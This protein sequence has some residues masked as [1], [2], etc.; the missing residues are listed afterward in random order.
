M[1]G[2]IN[3]LCLGHSHVDCPTKDDPSWDPPPPSRYICS[4][5]GEHGTHYVWN[6]TQRV[7]DDSWSTRNAGDGL[8]AAGSTQGIAPAPAHPAE[9][10]KNWM[11]PKR[12][13]HLESIIDVSQPASMKKTNFAAPQ[14]VPGALTSRS[15]HVPRASI[16]SDKSVQFGVSLHEIGRLSP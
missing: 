3:K 14:R 10:L 12:Q 8:A 11:S 2:S 7:G 9:A 16:E 1:D 4:I 5:C 15:L 6:C 13:I